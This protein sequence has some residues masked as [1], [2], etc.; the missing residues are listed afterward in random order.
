MFQ[1]SVL[2]PF[3]DQEVSQET[4]SC[5]MEIVYSA[6]LLVDFWVTI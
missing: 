1:R 6:Y 2:P 4:E 3:Q 5:L